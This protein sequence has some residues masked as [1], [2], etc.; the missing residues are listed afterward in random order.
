MVK[1]VFWSRWIEF[2]SLVLI[3]YGL[4]MVFAP[5]M[6]NNTLVAP[7][8]FYQ[9]EILRSAFASL[10]APQMTLLN[11]LNGLVGAITVGW[12]IQ[13][14]W[15]AHKPFRDGE[16]WAWNVLA[17]SVIVWA[18][19]EFYVKLT[20]GVGGVGLFAHFGLLIAFAIPLLATYRYFHPLATINLNYWGR[21]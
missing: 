13:I 4:V 6:M 14:G 8:L 1:L 19:L 9:T 12:S 11:V 18:A 16:R 2:L 5:E 17:A 7:L 20:M 21:E 3:I 15:L 10:A